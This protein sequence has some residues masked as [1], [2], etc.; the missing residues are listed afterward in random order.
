MTIL[1]SIGRKVI[2]LLSSYIGPDTRR[3][4]GFALPF[5]PDGVT[6]YLGLQARLSQIWINIWSFLLLL[7]LARALFAISSLGSEMS[8]AKREVLSSCSSV[9]TAGSTMASMPHYLAQGVN[10]LTSMGVEEAIRGL[11]SVLL[12]A[13]SGVENIT[14]FFVRTMYST[15]LSL[16]TLAVRGSAEVASGL[17]EE[18]S[19]FVNRTAKNIGDDVNRTT[20][21][22]E[23]D[24]NEFL[25]KLNGAAS[26]SGGQVPSVDLANQTN[27]LQQGI[28]FPVSI[29]Y[30]IE[31]L[32]G[33]VP[34]FL[35]AANIT[36]SILS[37]PF[38]EVNR[39]IGQYWGNYSFDRSALPV[40]DKKQLTFCDGD[41]G[42]RGF[43]DDVSHTVGTA[44]KTFIG[45]LVVLAI[46]LCI[47]L[48]WNE[49]QRWRIMKQRSQLVHN[50]SHD[51]MDVVYLVH[52]PYTAGAG[53]R[54]ASR[55]SNTR[56][57]ILVRWTVAYA[58][59]TSALFLLYIGIA[60]LFS[61]L[62]QYLL[63][64]SVRQ[65]AIPDM[66]QHLSEFSDKVVGSLEKT[67]LDW[68]NDANRVISNVNNEVNGQI[69]D[70]VSISTGAL[71]DTFNSFLENTTRV[72]NATFGGTPLSEPMQNVLD[73]LVLLKSN[74]IENGLAWVSD[75]TYF[76]FPVLANDTFSIGIS[77]STRDGGNPKQDSSAS[78][79]FTSGSD[80]DQQIPDKITH[81][82]VQVVD[83]LESSIRTEAIIAFVIVLVW[84]AV[85]VFGIL[86]ALALYWRHERTR[87]EGGGPPLDP[88]RADNGCSYYNAHKPVP[89]DSNN[90]VPINDDIA[91][92][93]FRQHP[94]VHAHGDEP[95]TEAA[96]RYEV[97]TWSPAMPFPPP[98]VAG[99]RF[100][101][102]RDYV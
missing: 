58:T 99:H 101:G 19:D 43:F 7:V 55:F 42:I 93:Q 33:S 62:C 16:V 54:A 96:P 10:E 65:H 82:V 70:L 38:E 100:P 1:S 97:A 76:S 72:L 32:N 57:Q 22:F 18:A 30:R 26:G 68:A 17:L 88:T 39:R 14:L 35:P 46:L 48:A 37:T 21:S 20:V 95:E 59:T 31:S 71:N 69:L 49:I 36:Q 51:P 52:R 94:A 24:L 80:G 25:A 34:N 84:I 90:S 64:R 56:K 85:A 102:Q 40:P 75:N 91:L 12:L 98:R 60:M 63:L 50:E 41:N 23:N 8:Y 3:S 73:Y 86:R 92:A 66:R 87:A 67:S 44:K 45:V 11:E 78:N 89:A 4:R 13:V 6:S 9:E 29:E 83:K 27:Q 61:C 47:P 79:V 77:N 5:P 53:V 74:G 28:S 2:P 15:Y 81:I